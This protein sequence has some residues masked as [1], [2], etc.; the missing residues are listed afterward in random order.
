MTEATTGNKNLIGG[1]DDVIAPFLNGNREHRAGIELELTILKQD[2]DGRFIP[3][4][5]AGNKSLQHVLNNPAQYGYGFAPVETS[6]EAAT[7][8]LEV[9]T[10]AVSF[11]DIE[12]ILRD[13]DR[14]TFALQTVCADKGYIVCPFAQPPHIRHEDL[15]GSL[16]E[17]ASNRSEA[18]IAAF[19]ARNLDGYCQ[20]FFLNN[21][22]QVSISYKD[23]EHLYRNVRRLAFLTSPLSTAHDNSS[24]YIEGKRDPLQTGLRLR[25]SL[26]QGGRGGAPDFFFTSKNGEDF[27]R[28]YFLWAFNTKLIARCDANGENLQAVAPGDE[29]S[30]QELIERGGGLNHQTNFELA[31]GMLWP[32]VKLGYI[33]G[34]N[35]KVTG[36]RYEARSCDAG[37]WRNASFPLVVAALAFDEKFGRNVDALLAEYGFS[38]NDAADSVD[39]YR[40][41]INAALHYEDRFGTGACT[42]FLSRFG[43]L[44]GKAFADIPDSQR[45]LKP[46]LKVSADGILPGVKAREQHP[47]LADALAVLRASAKNPSGKTAPD[48]LILRP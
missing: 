47:A 9:K 24:G 17:R 1:I 30:F 46:F 37:G 35:G 29:L 14:Q 41:S 44:V 39:L 22:V 2:R 19:R 25:E 3:I 43:A 48:P 5:N 26:A 10:G 11:A 4:D 33:R 23:P 16:I 45:H 34:V 21:A 32:H 42:E 12:A 20:N 28:N 36:V 13:L 15:F 18:F 40:D 8:T 6:E 38:V 31:F 7:L 27:I